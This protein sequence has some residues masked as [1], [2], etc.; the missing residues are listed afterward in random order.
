MYR[1]GL[2]NSTSHCREVRIRGTCTHMIYSGW[3][4]KRTHNNEQYPESRLE[5]MMTTMKAL[6]L[7]LSCNA[8]SQFFFLKRVDGLC[9]VF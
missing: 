5:Q 8:E 1:E 2:G 4:E 7:R 9:F 6:E 3:L